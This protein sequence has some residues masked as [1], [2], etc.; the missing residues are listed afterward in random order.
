[1][2]IFFCP[3]NYES[4]KND[5]IYHNTLLTDE[6]GRVF[7]PPGYN[8]NGY[9]DYYPTKFV[10]L[11]VR[12]PIGDLRGAFRSLIPKLN[13][14]YH[15]ITF[16]DQDEDN[17]KLTK[18]NDEKM[19]N[20]NGFFK[21]IYACILAKSDPQINIWQNKWALEME[22]G[23][24]INWE[25]VWISV[26]NKMLN[27]KM[28][29]SIWEMIHRNYI[30]GYILKQM[31]RSDGL[32]KLCNNLEQ[33]RTHVFMSCE[34]IDRLYQHF[35]YILSQ[36][37]P[38]NLSDK[39]RAFGIYEQDDIKSKLR[40]YITYAIRHIVFR[41]RNMECP[42]NGAIFNILANKI[43]AYIKQDV[44]ERY[45]FYKYKNKLEYFKE[46]YLLDGVIGKIE[47]NE[48]SFAL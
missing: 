38:T 42:T 48:L 12:V 8:A 34:V 30:C 22:N 3:K 40:N 17:F 43:K 44:K 28:Q 14:A 1:M 19:Y 37:G 24:D 6:H 11:P 20:I 9:P 33:N 2:N 32:C 18:L 26:H 7:K 15:N 27:Y 16:S 39:E 45:Y 31:N 29:S 46:T 35:S 23:Q 5:W 41:S 36:L 10:D 13:T 4:I 47:N 21:D 25:Q